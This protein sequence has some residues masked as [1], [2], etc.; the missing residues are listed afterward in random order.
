VLVNTG[1]A[2]DV[3]VLFPLQA[4]RRKLAISERI[5]KLTALR[6]NRLSYIG[7][8]LF[9]GKGAKP[10]V[11]HWFLMQD[12]VGPM[13]MHHEAVITTKYIQGGSPAIQK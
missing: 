5:A 10:N 13:L 8:Q 9:S 3:I 11:D 12:G 6:R 4:V 7:K 1:A 2:A